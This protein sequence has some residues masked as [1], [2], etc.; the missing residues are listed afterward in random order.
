MSSSELIADLRRKGQ[1][2]IDLLWEEA[3]RDFAVFEAEEAEKLAAEGKRCS[4]E[5]N[6]AG[7]AMKRRQ[8]V[9][10]QRQASII[11]N[12][13]EQDLNYRL[14]RLAGTM[15][16]DIRSGS[17][18]ELLRRLMDE[19]PGGDWDNVRVHPDD[20]AAARD[21]FPAGVIVEDPEI[22]GGLIVN[23]SAVGMTVVNTLRKRLE[24]AWLTLGPEILREVVEN[25]NPDRS[26]L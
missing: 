22:L 7:R 13:A 15:L 6:A 5:A 25:E 18:T 16:E 3:R 8:R 26:S 9:I 21:F 20:V 14:F 11:I 23:S 10:A 1:V 2:R 17:R 12:T 24:T 19:V 4:L